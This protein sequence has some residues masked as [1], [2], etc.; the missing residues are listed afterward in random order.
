MEK[1][2]RDRERMGMNDPL[3]RKEHERETRIIHSLCRNQCL[4]VLCSE[5]LVALST[6]LRFTDIYFSHCAAPK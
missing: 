5:Y 3:S 1:R 6:T 4:N 2:N